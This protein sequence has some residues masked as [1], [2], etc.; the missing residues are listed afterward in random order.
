MIQ[1]VRNWL[2][3]VAVGIVVALFGFSTPALAHGGHH[4][5]PA[6]Q[7]T[8]A[9]TDAHDL[10]KVQSNNAEVASYSHQ[11]RVKSDVAACCG[12]SCMFAAPQYDPQ[13]LNVELPRSS[14]FV[15]LQPE[16]FGRGPSRLDRP[17][18]A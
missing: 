3:L 18:T 10:G 4:A 15:P 8:P 13:P 1:A 2:L 12:L 11:G 16:L 9:T 14:L 7:A 17:P 5:S 6:V